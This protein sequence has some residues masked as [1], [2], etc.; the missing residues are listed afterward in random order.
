MIGSLLLCALGL[1]VCWAGASAIEH[2]AMGWA[3]V[4][5]ILA[6]VLIVAGIVRAFAV[7]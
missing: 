4:L 2:D 6:A 1:C 3:M 5:T 7:G